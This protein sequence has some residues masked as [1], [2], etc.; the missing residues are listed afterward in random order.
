V[1]AHIRADDP[2]DEVR[3]RAGNVVFI[4]G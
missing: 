3:Q 2:S 1:P 4:Y